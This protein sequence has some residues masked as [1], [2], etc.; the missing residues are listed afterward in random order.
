VLDA[1]GDFNQRAG[2]PG[3]EALLDAL[4]SGAVPVAAA[5][6]PC[7]FGGPIYVLVKAL[8]AWAEA[9]RWQRAG[10]PAVPVFWIGGDDHDRAEVGGIDVLHGGETE[11]THHDASDDFAELVPVGPQRPGVACRRVHEALRASFDA[12]RARD[13]LD[14]LDDA[15]FA[16]DASMT[17]GF[18][19]WLARLLG[20]RAPLFLD[21][22]APPI[23]EAT[24]PAVARVLD[25]PEAFLAAARARRD[26][27]DAAGLRAPVTVDDDA[28]PFFVHDGDGRRRR[29][30]LGGTPGRIRLRGTDDEMAADEILALPPERL[31]PNV[32][33]RPLIQEQLLGAGVR[34]LG[35]SEHAYHAQS[36]AWAALLRDPG[37]ALPGSGSAL[38]HRPRVTVLTARDADRLAE[39]GLGLDDD[40]D[41][42][43][44]RDRDVQDVQDVQDDDGAARPGPDPDDPRRSLDAAVDAYLR[45]RTADVPGLDPAAAKLRDRVA[46]AVDGFEASRERARVAARRARRGALEGT[47]TRVRPGGR[48][49]DRAVSGLSFLLRFGDGL[50][51]AIAERLLA[52]EGEGTHHLVVPR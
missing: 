34:V 22:T 45:A 20:P 16:D 44:D 31:S 37:T 23:R 46:R 18:A 24:R 35:P 33:L 42:A 48:P 43:P 29:A 13:V 1:V 36:A 8:G 32:L 17:L 11:P 52:D 51:E 28:L 14:A 4:G 41:A 6:Q 40:P 5:H 27:L 10:T 47:L 3:T 30:E 12:P 25:H 19:R 7:L 50:V 39:A 9:A 49:Q 38:L 2:H 26:A 15:A 21:A